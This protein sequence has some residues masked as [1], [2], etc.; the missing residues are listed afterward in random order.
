MAK[1][2]ASN[3]VDLFTVLDP[4]GGIGNTAVAAIAAGRNSISVE[5]D[6]GYIKVAN[7]NIKKAIEQRRETGAVHAG[8]VRSDKKK[9]NS[10]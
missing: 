5:I 3:I 2:A 10:V 9:C 8:L 4:F 6:P 1:P 7:S